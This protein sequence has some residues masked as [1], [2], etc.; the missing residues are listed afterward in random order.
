MPYKLDFCGSCVLDWE[1]IKRKL[2]WL[3]IFGHMYRTRIGT[4]CSPGKFAWALA[5]L[6]LGLCGIVNCWF[7]GWQEHRIVVEDA[8]LFLYVL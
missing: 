3:V 7:A 5:L 6:A 2:L 1:K 4:A 8:V